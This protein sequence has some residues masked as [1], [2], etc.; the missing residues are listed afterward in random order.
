[1]E[2]RDVLGTG[3]REAV[4]RVA[5][6]LADSGRYPY[7]Q[8]LQDVLRTRYGVLETRHLLDDPIVRA[9]IDQRCTAAQRKSSPHN[10]A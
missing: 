4:R 7:W 3:R 5:Y 9:N 1:M 8:A 6:S 2:N 10:G